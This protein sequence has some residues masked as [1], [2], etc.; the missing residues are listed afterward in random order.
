MALLQVAGVACAIAFAGF[1]LAYGPM[2]LRP[3]QA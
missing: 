2:L 3:R 1:A